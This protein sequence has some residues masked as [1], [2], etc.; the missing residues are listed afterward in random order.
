MMILS[1]LI[2]EAAEVVEAAVRDNTDNSNRC[3]THLAAPRTSTSGGDAAQATAPPS[4]GYQAPQ[5]APY[6][7]QGYPSGA[8]PPQQPYPV[9]P[10]PYGYPPAPYGY[11]PQQQPGQPPAPYGYPPQQPG[12]QP[13][14]HGYPP[15]GYPPQQPPQQ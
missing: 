12:Q 15:Y 2:T 10:Y 4:T 5:Y 13:P 3:T 14:P 11:P 8:A 6:P 1:Q 7:M 9:H